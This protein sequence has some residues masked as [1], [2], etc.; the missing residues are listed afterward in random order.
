MFCVNIAHVYSLTQCFRSYGIDAR[1]IYSHT[2]QAERK[3]LVSSFKA[4]QFPVLVN[5][6]MCGYHVSECQ[7]KVISLAILTEGADIPNI[8][9]VLIARPTRSRNVFAQM[10]SST[11]YFSCV[12]LKLAQDRSGNETIFRN[13]QDRLSNHRFCRQY[14]KSVWSHF[15]S[16][17]IRT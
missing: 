17:T 16:N 15:H 9:C 2:P 12:H 8:D 6:G 7:S 10:V 4:G 5:C 11:L 13:R 3:A 14:D 1:Y